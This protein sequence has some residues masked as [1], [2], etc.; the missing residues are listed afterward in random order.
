MTTWGS[1]R[2]PG[3][4]GLAAPDQHLRRHQFVGEQPT[5]GIDLMDDGVGEEHF[6]SEQ[7]RGLSIAMDAMGQQ[8][9]AYGAVVNGPLDA[10]VALVVAAHEPN[11]D[12]VGSRGRFSLHYLQAL[13][14]G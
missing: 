14:G 11:L 13:L 1:R 5:G 10:Q 2:P 7:W 4:N 3:A 6:A 12:K 9:V 8:D